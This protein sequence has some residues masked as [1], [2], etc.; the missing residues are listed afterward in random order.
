MREA[1]VKRLTDSFGGPL[2]TLDMELL[3]RNPDSIVNKAAAG[4]VTMVAQQEVV[5]RWNNIISMI[6]ELKQDIRT[7]AEEVVDNTDDEIVE[8]AVNN[9]TKSDNTLFKLSPEVLKLQ[10]ELN[11]LQ[12]QYAQTAKK[13][14]D[15]KLAQK[16]N[17]DTAVAALPKALKNTLR[18]EFIKPL[19]DQR[20]AELAELYQQKA[21]AV[22]KIL[23]MAGSHFPAAER[24]RLVDSVAYKVEITLMG[25]A[26]DREGKNLL[27]S[28]VKA[29]SKLLMGQLVNSMK[30]NHALADELKNLDGKMALKMKALIVVTRETVSHYEIPAAPPP[31]EVDS[32]SQPSKIS[33]FRMKP[34]PGGKSSSGTGAPAA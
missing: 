20:Q 25:T 14:A 12:K 18:P 4:Y 26:F 11:D 27:P 15:G 10:T 24:E 22:D 8:A 13:L 5:A 6:E 1:L 21:Q 29:L 34:I 30:E 28:E 23:H 9:S 31:P 2:N 3:L 19:D 33:P 17:F 16:T 32:K 7:R